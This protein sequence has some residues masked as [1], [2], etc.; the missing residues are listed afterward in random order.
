LFGFGNTI[1][2]RNISRAQPQQQLYAKSQQMMGCMISP[3][4]IGSSSQG[5]SSQDKKKTF[6]ELFGL[7]GPV[8]SSSNSS[9]IESKLKQ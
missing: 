5:N 1:A 3:P 8:G 6:N 2:S 4:T 7:S 9:K